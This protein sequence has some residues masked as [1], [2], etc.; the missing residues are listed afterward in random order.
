MLFETKLATVIDPNILLKIHRL[1]EKVTFGPNETIFHEGDESE[2][3]YISLEGD[4]YCG[5]TPDQIWIGPG[6][7][8]GEIGYILGTPRTVSAVSGKSGCTMWRTH[9][10]YLEDHSLIEIVILITHFLIGLAPYI[11]LRLMNVSTEYELDPDLP[12]SHCDHENPGIQ[13]ISKFLKGKDDWES[14]INI[15]EF[16]RNMP[17]RFGFWNVRASE[18]LGL[19]FGMCTTKANLQVALLRALDIEAKFGECEVAVQYLVPFLPPAYRGM[20]TKDIKHYFGIVYLDG[21]AYRCDASFTR[22]ALQIIAEAHPEYG[23]IVYDKFDRGKEFAIEGKN[24]KNDYEIFDNLSHVM[25][26]RPFFNSENAEAMNLFL[27]R[28]QGSLRPIPPW[29][30]STRNLLSYNPKAARLKALAGLVSDLSKLHSVIQ[31]IEKARSAIK[32]S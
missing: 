25:L 26:K 28:Y 18:T 4:I 8:L 7:I 11:N 32:E 27:D 15:W 12:H 9:R 10:Q 6:D 3:I 29:V 5:K 21:K 1:G 23:F 17:Y 30:E 22:E 2:F 19:G 16:V 24:E 14:A 20:I 31:E 13:Q